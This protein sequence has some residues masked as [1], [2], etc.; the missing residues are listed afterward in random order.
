MSRFFFGFFVFENFFSEYFLT[1][2]FFANPVWARA[3]VKPL[4]NIAAKRRR[5]RQNAVLLRLTNI[6][7]LILRKIP[8]KNFGAVFLMLKKVK[9]NYLTL[10]DNAIFGIKPAVMFRIEIKLTEKKLI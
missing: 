1:V 4:K 9:S 10:F 3:A 8:R 7:L 5:L 2:V 6:N